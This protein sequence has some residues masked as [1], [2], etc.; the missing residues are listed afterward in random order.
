MSTKSAPGRVDTLTPDQERVLK[1]VWT[2]LLHFWGYEI[3]PT[4]LRSQS[5]KLSKVVSNNSTKSSNKKSGG[6]L[7]KFKK[8]SSSNKKKSAEETD[9]EN[10]LNEVG[11]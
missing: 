2:Y 7:S 5:I 11:L 1:D 9:K 4:R 3:Q 8:N 10:K 6:F